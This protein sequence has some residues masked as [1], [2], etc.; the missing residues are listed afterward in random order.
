MKKA[1]SIKKHGILTDAF[2]THIVTRRFHK[3]NMDVLTMQY[4]DAA[5]RTHPATATIQVGKYRVGQRIPIKYLPQNPA[6]YAFGNV[7]SYRII[8]VF[9]ILLFLFAVFASYKIYEAL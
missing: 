2:I 9:C 1:N 7:S 4:K 8:L 5:G 3:T 6:Q